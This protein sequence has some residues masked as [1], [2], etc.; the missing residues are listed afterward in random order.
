MA[1]TMLTAGSAAARAVVRAA[2]V[3]HTMMAR[4]MAAPAALPTKTVKGVRASSVAACEQR[5]PSLAA[6]ELAALYPVVQGPAS[7]PSE[8]VHRSGA[9]RFASLDTLVDALEEEIAKWRNENDAAQRE[10]N[11]EIASYHVPIAVRQLVYDT[12]FVDGTRRGGWGV[13]QECAPPAGARG[14]ADA[15]GGGPPPRA[16]RGAKA[17]G[18]RAAPPGSRAETSYGHLSDEEVRD[19]IAKIPDLPDA[20]A[21]KLATNAVALCY[22]IQQVCGPARTACPALQ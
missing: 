2:A 8:V 1:A 6:G 7:T 22:A 14:A 9:E 12:L 11:E 4:R 3:P 19:K 16:R 13:G 15:A 5:L 10:L 21:R 20:E 17:G 18:R